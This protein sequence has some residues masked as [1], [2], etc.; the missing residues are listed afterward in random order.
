[1]FIP[2]SGHDALAY[3]YCYCFCVGYKV[4]AM[5]KKKNLKDLPHS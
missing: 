5:S 3:C 2:T 1:M 4:D